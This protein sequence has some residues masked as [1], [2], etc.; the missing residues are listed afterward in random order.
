MKNLLSDRPFWSA[1]SETAKYVSSL[2]LET[3][4]CVKAE[5]NEM[6]KTPQE[7]L[8]DTI[9]AVNLFIDEKIEERRE[10]MC[11]DLYLE[12]EEW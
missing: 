2:W 4:C 6:S 10:S 5:E 7:V 9:K 8:D 11:C 12:N 3:L 1:L